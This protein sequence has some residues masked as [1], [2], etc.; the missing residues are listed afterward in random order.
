MIVTELIKEQCFQ[1]A[2]MAAAGT[3]VMI[4]YQIFNGLL[5]VIS[6]SRGIAGVSEIVFWAVM[7][8]L[9]WHFLYYCA[10]GRISFHSAMAFAAG[11]LLWKIF[12]YDIIDKIY[13]RIY[14][15]QG[16]CNKHGE[17]ETQQSI[18]GYQSGNRH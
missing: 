15:K 16:N 1:C 6:V 13:A 17:K 12:F 8:S 3:G 11:A 18:Q 7:A 4:L 10:Y 9:T 14:M 2:V 5:R